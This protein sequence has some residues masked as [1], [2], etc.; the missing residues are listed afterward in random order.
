MTTE[1]KARVYLG[2]LYQEKTK[3]GEPY[4]T[5]PLGASRLT[6]W[7]SKTDPQKWNL[8]AVESGEKKQGSAPVKAAPTP[9]AQDPFSIADEDLPF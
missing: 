3:S 4:F 6:L 9:R 7:R 5:G 1:Q 2:T 8:Y